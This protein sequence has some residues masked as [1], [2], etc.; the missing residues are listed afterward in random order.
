LLE[1]EPGDVLAGLDGGLAEGF[2]QRQL[3]TSD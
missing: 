2:E 1:G 3:T